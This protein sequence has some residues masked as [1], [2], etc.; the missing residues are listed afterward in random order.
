MHCVYVLVCLGGC[1]GFGK[2]V[3]VLIKTQRARVFVCASNMFPF[4]ARSLV[5]IRPIRRHHQWAA[6]EAKVSIC[7]RR[8]PSKR[9]MFGV[10]GMRSVYIY[11]LLYVF[12]IGAGQVSWGLSN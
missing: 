3:G 2:G 7:E 10:F 11:I 9:C 4:K 5:E 12:T 1:V 8:F 6:F